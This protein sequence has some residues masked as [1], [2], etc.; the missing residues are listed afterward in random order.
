MSQAM[1]INQMIKSL[2]KRN[3]VHLLRKLWHMGSGLAALSLYYHFPNQYLWAQIAIIIGIVGFLTDYLRIRFTGLNQIIY[4]LMGPFMRKS[5][6]NGYSGLPFYALGVGFSL[7][8]FK[9]NIALLAIT[10]LVFSD[11]ISSYFGIRFGKD[12]ILPN[13]SLQGSLAG[14]C[15]CYTITLFSLMGTGVNPIDALIFSLIA[16]I[17]GSASEFV[18]AFKID[19]NLTI[20]II[21]GLGLTIMNYF[22]QV[23]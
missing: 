1:E 15:T 10:F 22:M 16:G 18:S 23:M 14:L 2:A 17:I 8:L 7:M 3:D 13:K 20:P 4:K 19:D 6:L 21:S 11:P 12:K 5:E 9:E